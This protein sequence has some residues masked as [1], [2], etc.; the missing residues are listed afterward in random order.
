MIFENPLFST[1]YVQSSSSLVYEN[2]TSFYFLCAALILQSSC[3]SVS[4]LVSCFSWISLKPRP[5]WRGYGVQKSAWLY[6]PDPHPPRL[7]VTLSLD[8]LP[9]RPCWIPAI[10]STAL[11]FKCLIEPLISW[12]VAVCVCVCVRETAE[13]G[14]GIVVC[15]HAW[16]MMVSVW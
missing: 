12:T 3:S 7:C 10:C 5:S 4:I 16:N 14:W 2:F 11:A 13:R 9:T 8:L 15:L 6:G 1:I